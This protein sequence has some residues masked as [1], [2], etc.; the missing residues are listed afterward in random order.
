MRSPSLSCSSRILC[1]SPKRRSYSSLVDCQDDGD[2]EAA[3]DDDADDDDDDD[4]DVEVPL[5]I[6]IHICNC[7]K[8]SDQID[9][10]LPHHV[11]NLG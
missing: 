3:D 5:L 8:C 10:L 4:D 9:L 1:S 6:L 11:C 7:R 2:S